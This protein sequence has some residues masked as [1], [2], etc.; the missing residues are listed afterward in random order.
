M[1]PRAAKKGCA[2]ANS[3]EFANEAWRPQLAFVWPFGLRK[4]VFYS[5]G[6]SRY[7]ISILTKQQR[8]QNEFRFTEKGLRRLRSCHILKA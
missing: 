6:T 1:A 2:V 7:K 5:C 3:L 4:L 8:S